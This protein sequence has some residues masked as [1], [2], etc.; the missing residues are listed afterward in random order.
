MALT[1]AETREFF[2]NAN[3]YMYA[4]ELRDAHLAPFLKRLD[5]D[6]KLGN[7]IVDAGS[8]SWKRF[9]IN[10]PGQVRGKFVA[11]S[12]LKHE[13]VT[14]YTRSLRSARNYIPTKGKRLIRF[15]LGFSKPFEE[16]EPGV[17]N[18]QGD[19]EEDPRSFSAR[20]KLVLA[21]RFL[22]GRRKVDTVVLADVLN[23]VDFK[24][25]LSN[26]HSFLKRGGRVIVVNT[27][28]RTQ[29]ESLLHD[30][31]PKANLDVVAHLRTLG[32]RV[33]HVGFEKDA[34][35]HYPSIHTSVPEDNAVIVARKK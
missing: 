3:H 25:V 1:K 27:V 6:G 8:A 20:R 2:T 26:V 16:I 19:L 24:R 32:M 21:K 23:Y 13:D 11:H 34:I 10:A 22:G 12:E 18:I 4:G 31:R 28:D 29:H 5:A 9:D 15:D 33:E 17:V 14:E 7:V 30:K 35:V